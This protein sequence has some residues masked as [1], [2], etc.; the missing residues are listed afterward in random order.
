MRRNDGVARNGETGRVMRNGECGADRY[1]RYAGV[2]L[3]AWVRAAVLARL[4]E[5]NV[6]TCAN[7]DA[8]MARTRRLLVFTTLASIRQ[9]EVSGLWG[10]PRVIPKLC[11]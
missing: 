11:T 5:T 7:D 2:W 8:R 3:M 1:D 10:Y 4:A 9:I 6:V